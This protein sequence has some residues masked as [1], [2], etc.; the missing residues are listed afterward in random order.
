MT[1]IKNRGIALK[2]ILLILTSVTLIFFLI[3]AYNYL[4][5]RQ[6]I[7]KNV[8]ENARNLAQA[9]VNR[10]ETILYSVEMV[11]KSLASFLENS[12]AE[13]IM[14]LLRSVI[15]NN[16]EIYGT[17]IAFEPYAHDTDTLYFA[18]YFY[19]SEGEIKFTYLGGDSY[20]YFFWD[21]YQI[22]KELD[23]PV[24]SEPYFDEG[25]GNIIMS[26]YSV[27]FYKTVSGKRQFMGIVTADISL[28][29]LQEIVASIKIAQTG[30]GFLISKNG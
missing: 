27:P 6:I 30:Y 5:S 8:E 28:A 12:S 10:I 11:P 9:T 15:E 20:R 25:G 4:L 24:W 29:W 16:S 2:L 22:P 3:F 14:N 7:I 26:T 17:T 21:W 23:C 13:Q 18:P 1:M 19:K